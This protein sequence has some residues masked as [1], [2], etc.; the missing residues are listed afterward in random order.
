MD[1]IQEKQE[2]L[3]SVEKLIDEG[4]LKKL[5]EKTVGVEDEI[6][7]IEKAI[8]TKENDIEKDQNQIKFQQSQ[9][10]RSRDIRARFRETRLRDCR[11]R[12]SPSRAR[13]VSS[14]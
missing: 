10:P 2:E 8:M 11:K 4:E 14:R 9:I 12:G 13:C 7:N 5:R 1:K 6:R 3:E